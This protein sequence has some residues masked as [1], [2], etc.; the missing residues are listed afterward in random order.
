MEKEF[1]GRRIVGKLKQL[2]GKGKRK[3]LKTKSH[4]TQVH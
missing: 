3:S 4:L 2:S 1:D